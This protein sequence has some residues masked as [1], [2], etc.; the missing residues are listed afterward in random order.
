MRNVREHITLSI[1]NQQMFACAEHFAAHAL[2]GSHEH[3]LD[4]LFGE[5]KAMRR[6]QKKAILALVVKHDRGFI[7]A[8]HAH[9]FFKNNIADRIRIQH[10]ANRVGNIINQIDFIIFFNQFFRQ[11]LQFIF[12]IRFFA[13]PFR[14]QHDKYA[15]LLRIMGRIIALDTDDISVQVSLKKKRRGDH[16]APFRRALCKRDA[17]P[18]IIYEKSWIWRSSLMFRA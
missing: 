1:F 2:A 18:V 6:R 5:I 9:R 10:R 11:I 17:L 13:K 12:R 4:L 7:H 14:E 3:M 16:A 15:A 8:D